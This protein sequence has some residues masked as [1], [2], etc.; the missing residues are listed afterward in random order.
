MNI[1][2]ELAK[3]VG[4]YLLPPTFSTTR[5]DE[6]GDITLLRE[7]FVSSLSVVG[8]ELSAM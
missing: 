4:K 8:V 1:M 3:Y 2:V 7:L 5:F 6:L